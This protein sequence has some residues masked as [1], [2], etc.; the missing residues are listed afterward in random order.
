MPKLAAAAILLITVAI[1]ALADL[2]GSYVLP[3]DHPAIQYATG[4]VRDPVSR[5]ATRL[6]SVKAT[7]A[8]DPNHGYLPAVLKELNVPISSQVLVFSKTSF[9][10]PRIAPRTPRALYFNDEVSVGWVQGGDVVEL[11]ALDPVRGMVFYTL[12]QDP[13]GKPSIERRGECLQCH[14]SG[15]TLGVPGMVVRSVFTEPSGMPMFQA[16]GYVTDHRSPLRERWGGWYVTG[17][18]GDQRHMG[19]LVVTNKENPRDIDTAK[20]ANVT[21]LANRIDTGAYL[22]PHSDIVALMVLEH[23]T[24]MTNLIIRVGWEA[25]MALHNQRAL[26]KELGEP[27]DQIS[28]S[29]RHRIESAADELLKYMLFQD[30][31]TLS[32]PVRGTS[33]FAADFAARTPRSLRDFD[34]KTRLFRNQCS[35]MIYSEAFDALPDEARNYI[36]ARLYAILQGTEKSSL[37]PESRSSILDALR[38]AKRG[39]PAYWK[40]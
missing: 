33:S 8:F 9:Q 36:Y 25:R 7:L 17:T 14:A 15:G 4:A 29:T 13:A 28:D 34:L 40:S 26:N 19:N 20:G 27:I 37:S 6:K 16:G 1:A 12:D 3:S 11:A 21:S 22:S 23:Q 38:M 24:R 30:E 18:H 10:A 31:A 2:D 35:Y 5:L 32:A 39:L